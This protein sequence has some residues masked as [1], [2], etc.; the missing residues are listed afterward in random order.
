MRSVTITLV[1][2]FS[3]T[4]YSQVMLLEIIFSILAIALPITAWKF[5][6]YRRQLNE[7]SS[8]FGMLPKH[9]LFGHVLHFLGPIEGNKNFKHLTKLL[10]SSEHNFLGIFQKVHEYVRDYGPNVCIWGIGNYM[11]LMISD[12]KDI[13]TLLVGKSPT[14]KAF[15]YEFFRSWLGDGLFISFGT[16]WFQM[17][18]ILTPTFHFK[19][20]EGFVD[21]FAAQNE[22]LVKIVEKA[23]QM[24]PTNEVNIYEKLTM[25]TLDNICGEFEFSY[26][27]F[28]SYLAVHF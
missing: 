6:T 21:V 12:A 7:L 1:A 2:H 10:S 8:H 5:F 27:L 16:K 14:K 19:I 13:E 26:L 24:S 3:R 17:R 15:G 9:F 25:C 28:S 23:A 22:C 11:E 20:L 4:L 18:R